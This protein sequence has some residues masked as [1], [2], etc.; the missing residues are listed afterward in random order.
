MHALT[1]PRPSDSL[2]LGNLVT[3]DMFAAFADSMRELFLA[4]RRRDSVLISDSLRAAIERQ[5]LDSLDRVRSSGQRGVAML[6]SIV[7]LR[8]QSSGG[9]RG[10]DPR[11]RRGGGANQFIATI[12]RR[13]LAPGEKR[14]LVPDFFARFGAPDTT[15]LGL[16]MGDSLR[17]ALAR[18]NTYF[19]ANARY[20]REIAGSEDM[21]LMADAVHAGAVLRGTVQLSRGRRDTVVVRLEISEPGRGGQFRGVGSRV[22]PLASPFAAIDSLMPRVL[23]E[24]AGINWPVGTATR[25]DGGRGR[26]P[27]GRRQGAGAGGGPAQPPRAGNPP[28]AGAVPPPTEFRSKNQ[29]M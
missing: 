23:A 5:I 6:D 29:E 24:L 19:P 25:T 18:T 2:S 13:E 3:E 11:G 4:E 12:L 22:V 28:A 26:N 10:G 17:Y 27:G 20:A 16:R 14:V 15:R 8:N 7:R 1:A 9:D 21:R